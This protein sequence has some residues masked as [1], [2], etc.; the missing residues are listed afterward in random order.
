[1]KM[2]KRYLGL[3]VFWLALVGGLPAQI[4]TTVEVDSVPKA[5][6]MVSPQY[7]DAVRYAG[8]EGFA[9]MSFV[10]NEQGEVTDCTVLEN[11]TRSFGRAAYL[12]LVQWRFSPGMRNGRI[13]RVRMMMPFAF[14]IAGSQFFKYFTFYGF[15]KQ[16]PKNLP[17]EFCY[18]TPPDPQV[19]VPPVYPRAFLLSAAWAHPKSADVSFLVDPAGRVEQVKVLKT[20]DPQFADSL[21]A[22]LEASKFTPARKK[23]KPCWAALA[24]HYTSDRYLPDSGAAGELLQALRA[25][26]QGIVPANELDASLRPLYEVGPVYPESLGA[27]GPAGEAV[28]EFYIDRDGWARFPQVI[29]ATNEAFGWAAATAISQWQFAPPMKK[30]EPVATMARIP[31]EFS[32]PKA[33]AGGA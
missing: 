11:S 13:A 18:D 5:I 32:A 21:T 3:A 28:V 12:A 19:L 15:A 24:K 29:S 20:D 7:P 25:G 10:V 16:P 23:G 26:G 9:L 8:V 33:Q 30:G 2:P 22:A 14:N 6:K 27:K 4:L 31:F 17:P 1:M